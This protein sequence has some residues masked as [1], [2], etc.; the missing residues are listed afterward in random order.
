[1]TSNPAIWPFFLASRHTPPV[2]M[3]HPAP[4]LPTLEPVL[5]VVH[6]SK[7][8][9]ASSSRPAVKWVSAKKPSAVDLA[10]GKVFDLCDLL[11]QTVARRAPLPIGSPNRDVLPPK[12]PAHE[13]FMP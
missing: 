1:M 10:R 4:S 2:V 6:R 13:R 7:P 5:V 3:K 9:H 8:R 11:D 12:L